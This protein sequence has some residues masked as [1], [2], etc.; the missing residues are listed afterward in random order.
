MTRTE[1]IQLVEKIRASEGTEK[2]LNELMD[3]FLKNVPD[4]NAGGY[5]FLKE[6]ENLTSEEIVAKAL[7][8]KP[9]ML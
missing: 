3:L 1:L 9:F 2:E 7:S 4:P 5:L 8:Y 6:Y